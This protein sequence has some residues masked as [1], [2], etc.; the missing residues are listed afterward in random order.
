MNC[1]LTVALRPQ[2]GHHLTEC[3]NTPTADGQLRDDFADRIGKTT[4]IRRAVDHEFRQRLFS[5][6]DHVAA[7]LDR[8][9]HIDAARYQLSLNRVS[10]FRGRDYDACLSRS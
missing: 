9:G 10:M 7:R 5:I 1:A 2:D 6:E 3:M 8:I 4:R